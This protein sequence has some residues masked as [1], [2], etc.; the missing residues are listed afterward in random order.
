MVAPNLQLSPSAARVPADVLHWTELGQESTP[1]PITVARRAEDRDWPDWSHAPGWSPGS[2][3]SP[4]QATGLSVR[5][6]SLKE[7]RGWYPEAA[8]VY[9]RHKS[10]VGS[11][12]GTSR[13]LGFFP[14]TVDAP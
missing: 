3:V 6:G 8:T 12:L 11:S 14:H 4:S 2:G 13:G 1:G 7:D 5:G 10:S 9:G